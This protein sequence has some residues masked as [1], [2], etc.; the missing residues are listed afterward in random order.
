[1]DF[2]E[3]NDKKKRIKYFIQG[4]QIYLYYWNITNEPDD[5]T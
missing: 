2:P 5:R 3:K 4:G 1:M